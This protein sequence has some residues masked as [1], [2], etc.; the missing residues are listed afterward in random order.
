[1]QKIIKLE[2][3]IKIIASASAV[4]HEEFFGPLGDL[5]DFH[6]DSDRFGAKT[7]EQAESEMERIA[8]N[9]ALKKASLRPSDIDVIFA[10]DLQ[11]QCVASSTGLSSFSIPYIGLYGACSTSAEAILCASVFLSSTT[12]I[13]RCVAITSSHN[14]AAERQ[15]RTPIEYGGQRTPTAQWTATASGAF[16]LEACDLPKN[17]KNNEKDSEIVTNEQK[18]IQKEREVFVSEVMPGKIVDSG[19]SDASNM[20]AAM[21]PACASSIESYFKMTNK[22][23][24]EFDLI[25]TGDLGKEGSSILYELLSGIGI[26]IKKNHVDCG[27]IMYDEKTQDCHSGGSGCGCSASILASHFI[28]SLREGKIKNI[29]FLATGALMSPSSIQQGTSIS[30]IAPLIRIES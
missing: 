5:F 26:D 23:P 8:L 22:S 9:L 24:S 18:G 28:P 21:A 1:M 20:G 30:G 17:T 29:L 15:F 14:C 7:W 16:I 3:K 11:N 13:K 4:G 27:S 25:V 6:D 2:K 10:G 19:V 12:D